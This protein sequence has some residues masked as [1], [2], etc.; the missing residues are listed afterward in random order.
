MFVF[1]PN[2]NR[3]LCRQ[4]S[5]GRLPRLVL[6]GHQDCRFRCSSG[7]SYLTTGP[8]VVRSPRWLHSDAHRRRRVPFVNDIAFF[9]GGLRHV[10]SAAS[11]HT[12]AFAFTGAAATFTG[13]TGVTGV[14]VSAVRRCFHRCPGCFERRGAPSPVR[15]EPWCCDSGCDSPSQPA[16]E[17]RH[18]DRRGDFIGRTPSGYQPDQPG[19]AV[20]PTSPIGIHHHCCLC[21][22]R[23]CT[24]ARVRMR[25][26]VSALAGPF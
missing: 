18:R 12:G 21:A 15:S 23:R 25:M 26:A 2:Y 8:S 20:T 24:G 22:R 3:L 11:G 6:V 5:P 10:G 19:M 7:C 16:R 13:V 1:R 9:V 17:A 4:R 14:T